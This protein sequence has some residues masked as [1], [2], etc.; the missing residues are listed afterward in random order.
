MPA[1]VVSESAVATKLAVE[2]L[3]F[4]LSLV[5]LISATP[6]GNDVQTLIVFA[7][8]IKLALPRIKVSIF[9]PVV[10]LDGTNTLV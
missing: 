8:E 5:V 9:C 7:P 6:F 2:I 3:V 10:A 4:T 1:Q